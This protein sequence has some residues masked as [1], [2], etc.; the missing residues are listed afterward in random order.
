[1][2]EWRDTEWVNAV[3]FSPDG[4]RLAT[5]GA[6]LMLRVGPWDGSPTVRSPEGLPHWINAVVFLDGG[7]VFA[8]AGVGAI[9]TLAAT[10]DG[11]R[12]AIGGSR[13]VRFL[14]LG[15]AMARIGR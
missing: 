3:A 11:L 1:V 5:G 14:D 15:A 10:S 8:S 2:N 12:M 13:A 6:G 4:N 7:R 9:H